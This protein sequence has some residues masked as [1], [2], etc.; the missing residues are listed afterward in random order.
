MAYCPNPTCPSAQ[1]SSLSN[2][3]QTCGTSLSLSD[4]YRLQ[5]PLGEGGLGRTFLAV[6]AAGKYYVIKQFLGELA[7][8]NLEPAKVFEAEVERLKRLGKHPQIPRLVDAIETGVGQFLVQEFIA[9]DNLEVQVAVNGPWPQAS[10]RSL[11]SS[12]ALVLQYVHSFDVIHRDIKPANIISTEKLPVLVDFGSAKWIRKAPAKTVIGSA[13]YSAPEQTMG[14][15]AFASDIYSLG[16]TCLYLLTSIHPFSLYSVAED[17]W[18]WRDYLP[19]PVEFGFA[20]VL[21]RMVA[22][23]LSHRYE[24]MDQVTLDLQISQSPLRHAPKN[25]LA[26]AKE[27]VAPFIDASINPFSTRSKNKALPNQTLVAA[28]TQ[29]W[30][31]CD[32]ITKDLGI[33]QAIALNDAFSRYP[34]F[35]TAGTDGSIRLWRLLDRQPIHTFSRRRLIGDG[36][37][38]AITALQ[39]HPDSRALY[40]ASAD[41]TIKEWDSGEYQLLNTLKSAGWTPTDVAVTSDGTQLIAA[42]NDGQIVLW[43]IATLEPTARLAQ[44]QKSINAIALSKRGDLLISASDDGTIKLWRMQDGREPQLSKIISAGKSSDGL[45]VVAIALH[46]SSSPQSIQQ[47]VAATSTGLVQ[48]YVLDVQMNPSEP[49][50]LCQSPMPITAFALSNDGTLAI[51]SEDSVLTLWDIDTSACVAKLAHGWGLVAI[52][53]SADSNTLI[54]ASAD[55][56]ISVWQRESKDTST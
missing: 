48:R 20:Q 54:T 28:D 25:L 11:L 55:E 42:Y 19:E 40:S 1:N 34:I 6:D 35:A 5:T 10:V 22:H 4:R 31:C 36:H 33:T 29:K 30:T 24:E 47:I 50:A 32:R 12:L 23:D 37:T 18:V 21:D 44:H 49:I 13:D 16:L 46:T 26:R 56:V 27:T 41:G 7:H 3:C 51:G 8:L 17:R 9:G 43:D 53:F 38:A 45:G 39:F 15:A 14:K 2:F 52:A